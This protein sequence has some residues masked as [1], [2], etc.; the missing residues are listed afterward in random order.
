[1]KIFEILSQVSRMWTRLNEKYQLDLQIVK[2]DTT[3]YRRSARIGFDFVGDTLSR[4]ICSSDR[5][6]S[7]YNTEKADDCKVRF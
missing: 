1:L 5:I 2:W 3:T 6:R 4:W 7:I